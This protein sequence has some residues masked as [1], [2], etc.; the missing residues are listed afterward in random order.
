MT[1]VPGRSVPKGDTIRHHEVSDAF[2]RLLLGP[3]MVCSGG[4]WED[5]EGLTETL[6]EAQERKLDRFVELAGAAGTRR[7]LDVG[8]GWGTMLN[9]LT[10][11]HGVEQAVGLTP[12]R[13]QEQFITGFGNPRIS[14]RVESWEDHTTQ[15]LYDAAFCINALEQVVPSV[16]APRERAERYRAFF[17]TV[18][19]VLKPG[20]RF[21][22]HTMTAETL[23]VN[24][25]LLEDLRFLRRADSPFHAGHIPHLHELAQAADGLFDVIEIVNERE[26]FAVACRAWLHRLAQCR[27]VAVVLAGEEVV[28]RFERCL[29]IF[30][31]TLEDKFF[32][33]F[34][35]TIARR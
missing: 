35:V 12:S 30:A 11:V 16:L 28:A 19:A 20:A 10:V 6:D 2:Y 26:S 5:G 24:G 14:A 1:T 3:T 8:C 27:D 23:P 21:V 31:Y 29:G 13:T 18:G 4:Y 25:R 9:R 32:N 7:V 34:R 15:D 22:L 17:S 33:N